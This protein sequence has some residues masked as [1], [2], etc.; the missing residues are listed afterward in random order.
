MN[1]SVSA[2]SETT[3]SR[4]GNSARWLI[5]S[6]MWLLLVAFVLSFFGQRF[7]VAELLSNFRTQFCVMFLAA[8]LLTRPAKTSWLLFACLVFAAAL[9]TWET[10][11]LFLPVEQSAAGQ[12]KIRV[13]SFNVLAVSEDYE[14]TI[15]EI[16]KHEPDIVAVLEYANMWHVAMNELN[17][18][19]PHQHRDPRWHGYG[20]AIFSKLPLENAESIPL[21]EA[22]IDNPSASVI[23]RVDD[24][25]VRIM[26]VHVMSPINQ[27]R[28]RLRNEQFAEIADL[29]NANSVPTIL[30]G[31][32]NCTTSSSFLTDL[33]EKAALRDSRQGLGVF[34]SWPSFAGPLAV[35]IDHVLVSETIHV[36]NRFL[37]NS[38]GSDHCPVVVDVSV[39]PKQ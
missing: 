39:S 11:K 27:N 18:T 20:I 31:D 30:V 17:E 7:L 14:A 25:L 8:L 38:C 13:M 9:T 24:Q 3:P 15:E 21:T 33:I 26:A 23:V 35:P 2:Q 10:G 32:M 6:G 29:V 36:H 1:E 37:G 22:Q 34:P 28:L 12:T 19:Y 5:K 4:F 16:K